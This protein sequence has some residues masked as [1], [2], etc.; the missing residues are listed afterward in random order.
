MAS[1]ISFFMGL[2][3]IELKTKV[4]PVP[5]FSFQVE[6][7]TGA[8]VMGVIFDWDVYQATI[9]FLTFI[10]IYTISGEIILTTQVFILT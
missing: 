2:L 10:S 7:S 9:F 3:S 1:K 8:M 6:I 4:Q 5:L